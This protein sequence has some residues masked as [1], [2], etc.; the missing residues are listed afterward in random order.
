MAVDWPGAKL[1][2]RALALTQP[3]ETRTLEMCTGV[4]V[5]LVIENRWERA[6]PGG[7]APNSLESSVNMASAQEP[8]RTGAVR[9]IAAPSTTLYR[10]ILG[11]P[12]PPLDE[13]TAVAA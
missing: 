2:C 3:Q 4:P 1:V 13:G 8:A 11:W 6:G 12:F 10:N 9:Q 7:T 5:L